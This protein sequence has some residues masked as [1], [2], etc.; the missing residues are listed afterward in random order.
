MLLCVRV[1]VGV[2]EAVR[3]SVSVCLCVRESFVFSVSRASGCLI[4]IW[5]CVIRHGVGVTWP[6]LF[7]YEIRV[8]VSACIRALE[9]T[10][11]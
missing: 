2:C 11:R 6:S 4:Q 7:V 5:Q 1:C 3:Q 10:E 8:F 9:E